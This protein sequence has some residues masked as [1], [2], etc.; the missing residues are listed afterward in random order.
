M[1]SG[2]HSL[3]FPLTLKDLLWLEVCRN[4]KRKDEL[5]ADRIRL[6]H[7]LETEKQN[8]LMLCDLRSIMFGTLGYGPD[9]RDKS[10]RAWYGL[11][12]MVANGVKQPEKIVGM[13]RYAL[14]HPD[15]NKKS[16]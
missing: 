13:S 11:P 12:S 15:S 2:D 7:Q 16:T 4:L 10:D 9:E 5:E 3:L 8:Y 1:E 6:E 14:K